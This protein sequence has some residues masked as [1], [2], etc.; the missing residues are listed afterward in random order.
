MLT[1]LTQEFT[2]ECTVKDSD[3]SNIP[4]SI[5]STI[6]LDGLYT[7]VAGKLEYGKDSLRL[8][9]RLESDKAKA[10]ATSIQSNEELHIFI[11]RMRPLIVPQR[12]TNGK[13]STRAL[14]AIVVHFEDVTAAEENS[15]AQL[16]GKAKKVCGPSASFLDCN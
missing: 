16:K 15:K 9:Y 2:I 11:R 6:T 14:K 3:G 8:R 12:L 7:L 13:I 4:F 10:G 1:F 5:T